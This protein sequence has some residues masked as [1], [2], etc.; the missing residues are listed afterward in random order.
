[1]VVVGVGV[2]LADRYLCCGVFDLFREVGYGK[3][4]LEKHEG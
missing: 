3:V 2:G 4:T 1:M